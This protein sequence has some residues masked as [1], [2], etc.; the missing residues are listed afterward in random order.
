MLV[1]DK[2]WSL[3]A[4]ILCMILSCILIEFLSPWAWK[5]LCFQVKLQWKSPLIK[6][7][8]G[9][10]VGN[11][12]NHWN[13]PNNTVCNMFYVHEVTVNSDYFCSEAIRIFQ[14]RFALKNMLH[15]DSASALKRNHFSKLTLKLHLEP[16]LT[17]THEYT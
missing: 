14:S 6:K 5:R 7:Y 17:E 15:T 12:V 9:L 2:N 4:C 16:Y 8:S 10:N 13:P 3:S 1:L 11:R